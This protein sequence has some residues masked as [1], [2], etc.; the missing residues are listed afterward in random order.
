MLKDHEHKALLAACRKLPHAKCVYRQ[1]DYVTNLFL[2]VLDF[3]LRV[4]TV[5]RA[6]G[7]YWENR[8]DEVRTL[9]DLERLFDHY[10]DDGEG[11]TALALHLWGYR[12]SRRA[13]MLRRLAEFFRDE[14][15]VC[16]ERLCA[17]A[18]GSDFARDFQGRV[19]GLGHAV[20]QALVMR[21]GVET[22][23]PDV[24]MHAFIC[25]AVGRMLSN[26]ETVEVLHRIAGELCLTPSQLDR[27]IWEHQRGQ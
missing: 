1:D 8:W 3:Q 27:A 23:K 5:N 18:E 14:G 13:G 19:R 26:E 9:E 24:H 2:T 21:Q 15:I 12:Y 22:V 7:H 4:V 25:S 17:W 20:Y 16:Q 6:V 10:P 11:N